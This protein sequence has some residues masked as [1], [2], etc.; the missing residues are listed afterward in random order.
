MLH[1]IYVV[2]N[3]PFNPFQIMITSYSSEGVSGGESGRGNSRSGCG[4]AIGRHQLH[5]QAYCV[6]RHLL[7]L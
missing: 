4:W 1:G 7:G 2:H 6:R 5:T 3:E